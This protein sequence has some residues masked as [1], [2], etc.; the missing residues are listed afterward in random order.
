MSY[1]IRNT[2][3]LFMVL[4]L[5]LGGGYAYIMFFQ[6]PQVEELEED[7]EQVET[8]LQTKQQTAA[9]LPALRERFEESERFIEEYDKTLFDN[10]NPD[11]V[12]RFLSIISS[13]DPVEFDYVFNDSTSTDQYGVLQ[14]QIT[15]SGSYRAV[16]NF[17]SRIE[18]SPP[19]QKIDDITITPINEVGRYGTVNF[20]FQLQSFYDNQNAF[21]TE[22]TPGVAQAVQISQNNP[23]YP[24]IR[25]VEP[26]EDDLL[27]AEESRLVGIGSGRVYLQHQNGQ[28]VT[29]RENDEVYLGRLE[30][31]D[32]NAGEVTFRLNKGGIIDLITLEVQR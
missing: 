31:I 11:R 25:N 22:G 28:L 27:D 10:N 30:T 26:N 19:V 3:I 15:G 2:I 18:H 24:L 12:Y 5:L 17:I 14:S 20:S 7:L 9:E 8:E 4:A 13:T 1:A 16:L 23:F 32:M 21:S 29:L 6:I